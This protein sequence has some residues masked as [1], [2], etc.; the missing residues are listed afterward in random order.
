LFGTWYLKTGE[1]MPGEENDNASA[2]FADMEAAI[3]TDYVLMSKLPIY[4]YSVDPSTG[5]TEG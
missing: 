4:D 5:I 2:A 3:E 1:T